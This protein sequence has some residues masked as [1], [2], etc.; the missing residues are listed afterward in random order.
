MI[1][2]LLPFGEHLAPSDREELERTN[3]L[4]R[5]WLMYEAKK[6]KEET[7]RLEKELKAAKQNAENKRSSPGSQKSAG[8][9][10]YGNDEFLE[11]FYSV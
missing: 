4:E 10:K 5:A 8:G 6:A 9:E 1:A 7:A 3:D 2:E 11:G